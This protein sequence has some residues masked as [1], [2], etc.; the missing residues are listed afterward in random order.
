MIPKIAGEWFRYQVSDCFAEHRKYYTD[1]QR[2]QIRVECYVAFLQLC[3]PKYDGEEAKLKAALHQFEDK[4]HH[5]FLRL[6]RYR[7]RKPDIPV[8]SDKEQSA[9]NMA[10][11]KKI[12]KVVAEYFLAHFRRRLNYVNYEAKDKGEKNRYRYVIKDDNVA[13]YGPL[14]YFLISDLERLRVKWL[15]K[16]PE[17]EEALNMKKYLLVPLG[18]DDLKFINIDKTTLWH[19]LRKVGITEFSSR[20]Y[21]GRED[22]GNVVL[23]RLSMNS[24]QIGASSQRR[25]CITQSTTMQNCLMES[26]LLPKG[27]S[28]LTRSKPTGTRLISAMNE[29][30]PPS[31]TRINPFGVMSM[32]R[33]WPTRS[34][35]C[36]RFDP[37]IPEPR[38][39]ETSRPLPML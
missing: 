14:I 22:C 37:A 38:I 34:S 32:F 17:D 4:V 9:N 33:H 16:D 19:L 13:E 11:E 3:S 27:P 2:R 15:E 24:Q 29:P 28:L 21:R 35:S 10:I 39:R 12:F 6:G 25:K 8:P 36:T 7:R 23:K 1:L 26:H 30:R 18:D 5:I 20:L 31:D